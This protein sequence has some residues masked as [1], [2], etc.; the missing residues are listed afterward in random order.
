MVQFQQ[1]I[2]CFM[3]KIMN[4]PSGSSFLHAN[5]ESGLFG[6]RAVKDSTLNRVMRYFTILGP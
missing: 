5:T 6:N 2:S 4:K 3:L 1:F